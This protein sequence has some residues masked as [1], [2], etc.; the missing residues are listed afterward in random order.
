[1]RKAAELAYAEAKERQDALKIRVAD[2]VSVTAFNA[3][4]M[5]VNVK[6]LVQREIAGT[7]VSPPPILAVKVAQIPL[8]ITVEGKTATVTPDIKPGDIGIVV[9]LDLDSDNA[10][11]TGAESQPNSSRVHSVDDAVFVGVIVP[12]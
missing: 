2:L 9:Y 10:A 6:P 4:K 11:M 1:M 3:A 12:G 7:Y 5:T 8:K